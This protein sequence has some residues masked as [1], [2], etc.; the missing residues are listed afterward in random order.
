MPVGRGLVGSAQLEDPRLGEGRA[1]QLHSDGHARAVKA[2]GQAQAAKAGQIGRY[3]QFVGEDHLQRIVYD[4][5]ELE[6]GR[7]GG[8][9][10]QRVHLTEEGVKLPP[11]ERAHRLRLAVIGIIIASR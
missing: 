2:A 4:R 7:R 11:D 1:E 8:R 10:Q 9:R 6:G 5:A 3:G